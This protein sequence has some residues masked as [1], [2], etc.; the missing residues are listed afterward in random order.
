MMDGTFDV[1]PTVFK[2]LYT[3]CV[4]YRGKFLPLVYAFLPNKKATTYTKLFKII[5][6]ILKKPVQLL[7]ID[8]ETG[9][10]AAIPKVRALASAKISGCNFHF[11]QNMWKHFST[12]GLSSH[13]HSDSNL[14]LIFNCVLA[15]A[16]L[17]VEEVRNGFEA[18]C[19][20]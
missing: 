1:A 2:Q 9:I 20:T 10:L 5:C 3:I 8:F 11:A 12:C 13:Y 7:D 19:N 6:S 17:P 16:Y 4:V 18:I 15:L 14:N